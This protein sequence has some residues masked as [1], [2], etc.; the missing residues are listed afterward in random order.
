MSGP[1]WLRNFEENFLSASHEERERLFALSTF[2]LGHFEQPPN[3][4]VNRKAVEMGI[5]GLCLEY[6]DSEQSLEKL[7]TGGFDE[8]L[9]NQWFL[10]GGHMANRF[11]AWHLDDTTPFD[12]D[13]EAK[14]S[15]NPQFDVVLRDD[16]GTP[17]C[18]IE[19]KRLARGRQLP[20]YASKFKEKCEENGM[21]CK[22]LLVNVFPI[23]DPTS[24]QRVHEFTGGTGMFAAAAHP[25]FYEEGHKQIVCLPARINPDESDICPLERIRQTLQE[26]LCL[27]GMTSGQQ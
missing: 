13:P 22:S 20:H 17:V 21:G 26:D 2:S 14:N 25:E 1:G 16:E 10:A 11:V 23:G 4:D 24:S 12:C 18:E 27:K 7:A 3:W 8:A 15:T 19:L 9:L 5:K 6:I